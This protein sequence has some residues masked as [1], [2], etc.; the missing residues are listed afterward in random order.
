VQSLENANFN[1][2]RRRKV[3]EKAVIITRKISGKKKRAKKKIE[4]D[5]SQLASSY[6]ISYHT[7]VTFIPQTTTLLKRPSFRRYRKDLK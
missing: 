4:D 5:A 6:G 1:I 3:H 7:L 2:G